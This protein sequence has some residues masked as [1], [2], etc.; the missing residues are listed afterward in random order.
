MSNWFR[1]LVLL[2][3]FVLT[4]IIRVWHIDRHFWLLGDQI[5]DWSIALGPFGELPLVGPPTHFGGYTVGPAFYWIL[6]LI[7]V[8]VGPWFD[9]LPHAGGIGQAMLQSGADT[10]LAAAVWQRT[11]SVWIALTTIVLLATASYDLCLAPLVWNPVIGSTLAKLATALV[12]LDWSRRSVLA[13]AV[14]GAVAWSAVHAYTGAV[15]VA[16]GVFVALVGGPS[17]QR[18]WQ[19]ARRNA[20]IIAGVVILLQLPHAVHQI[21]TGFSDSAMGIVTSSVLSI[22]SGGEPLQLGSS[23]WGYVRAFNSIQGSPWHVPWAAWV[24]AACSV[25]VAVRYR[26]DPTLLAVTLLPQPAAIAGFAFFL[27]DL[28]NYYYLSL[29]PGAV[30]TIVL[31]A[32][33][34]PRPILARAISI[35]L[36]IGC[37]ALVPARVRYAALLHKMPEYGALVDGSRKIARNAH[38]MRAIETEFRLPRTSDR[39]YLYRI[40]G[41][42]ID[43]ES[44]W[45]GVIK[46]DGS[47]SFEMIKNP[48]K[49]AAGR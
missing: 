17:A 25:I 23:L 44:P 35:A 10:V 49:P 45:I 41:G 9:N 38:P 11:G 7:R 20:L 16:L 47:V 43:R 1:G 4:L 15:F 6:W 46:R 31:G 33:A 26:H 42:R 14:T 24:L 22:L 29:M 18:D 37:L 21:S 48:S 34:V 5:R 30:L 2:L 36:F 8:V 3:T 13:V 28:D 19:K 39:E 40:L 12:L 32:T 27:G